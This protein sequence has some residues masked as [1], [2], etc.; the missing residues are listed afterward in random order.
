MW[1][2]LAAK[3]VLPVE[4]LD[5]IWVMAAWFPVP[6]SLR[7]Y[8]QSRSSGPTGLA[9][10]GWRGWGL[11]GAQRAAHLTGLGVPRWIQA[12]ARGSK[13][14]LGSSSAGR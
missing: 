7:R 5:S 14:H 10:I 6:H 13:R 9:R 2:R 4:M 8:G 3:A 1:S 11:Q 12:A